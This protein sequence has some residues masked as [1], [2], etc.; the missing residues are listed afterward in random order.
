M[1]TNF[2]N[3]LL[4]LVKKVMFQFFIV[5]NASCIFICEGYC[6]HL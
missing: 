3:G 6:I 4:K 1:F 5:L 2:K